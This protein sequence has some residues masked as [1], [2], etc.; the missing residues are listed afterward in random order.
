M[1]AAFN[2][3]INL[4]L[5][6]KGFFNDRESKLA[7]LIEFLSSNKIKILCMFPFDEASLECVLSWTVE[8]VRQMELIFF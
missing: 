1:S 5:N 7:S 8:K 4:E 6:K 3:G 2:R